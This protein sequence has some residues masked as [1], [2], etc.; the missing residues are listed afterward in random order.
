MVNNNQSK[1]NHFDKT[2]ITKAQIK[3]FHNNGVLHL[4]N[5]MDKQQLALLRDIADSLEKQ[6]LSRQN[7][8]LFDDSNISLEL[9]TPVLHRI[10]HIH[11]HAPL[12]LLALLTSDQLN[13]IKSVL[14]SE[15]A[16]PTAEMMIF[17]Q[18]LSQAEIPWH[19]DFIESSSANSIITIGIYLDDSQVGDGNVQFIPG[20]HNEKQDICRF[21]HGEK[22]L[23]ELTEFDVQ[24]GDIIVHNPMVVHRSGLMQQHQKRR[25][26]Y[27]EFRTQENIQSQSSWPAEFLDVRKKLMAVAE[28]YVKEAALSVSNDEVNMYQ[29]VVEEI[30]QVKTPPIP[31]NYCHIDR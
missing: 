20:T 22:S 26:L 14:C 27:Y 13:H 1:F 3:Q 30:F 28:Q 8:P 21:I 29:Y 19:Q 24:A 6:A 31:A 11:R 18:A 17:K 16:L 25:T 7:K 15:D 10:K 2:M 4:K 9:F 12:S 23:G 5:V